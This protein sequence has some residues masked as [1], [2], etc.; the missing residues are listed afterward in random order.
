MTEPVKVR[1]KPRIFEAIR[2]TP[3][4]QAAVRDFIGTWGQC[5]LDERTESRESWAYIRM[6]QGEKVVS[7]GDW[8]LKDEAGCVFGMRADEFERSY[9]REGNT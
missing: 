7:E 4:N 5:F 3:E 9:L 1:R 2:L 6:L 8:L